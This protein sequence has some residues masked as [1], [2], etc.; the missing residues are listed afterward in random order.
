MQVGIAA[1][2]RGLQSQSVKVE[3]GKQ[4]ALGGAGGA[5][6]IE[7]HRAFARLAVDGRQLRILRRARVHEVVPEGVLVGLGQFGQ[8][9]ALGHDKGVAQRRLQ[10]IA[11]AGDEHL[12]G[13][14][15]RRQYLLHLGVELVE[16]QNGL[17]LRGVEV[18]G[19]LARRGKGMDHRGNGADAVE[20]VE[21]VHRLRR[22]GHGD[23]H[24]V[25]F[26]DAKGPQR[27][28]RGPYA[29]KEGAVIGLLA[30]ELI[31]D[32]A[33]VAPRAVLDHL[34]HSLFRVVDGTR[35]VAV[36]LQP[37]GFQ[38]FH[39]RPS[40]S[41]RKPKWAYSTFKH[42]HATIKTQTC[43]LRSHYSTMKNARTCA[44]P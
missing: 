35:R 17:A 24:A 41:K 4:D 19:D 43:Q 36:I 27:L 44:A 14:L 23:G 28:G 3:V 2:G 25:A 15:Q 37:R 31:G 18:K 42:G 8:L 34:V 9:A 10:F 5:A 16:R 12:Y 32:A 40:F 20:G 29:G 30:H 13:M 1:H 7:D 22:V 38:R 6:G 33:G 39:A 21:S 26:A 11:D